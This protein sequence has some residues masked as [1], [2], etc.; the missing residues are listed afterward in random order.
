[1]YEALENGDCTDSFTRDTV[2]DRLEPVYTSMAYIVTFMI[3]SFILF[4]VRCH[5]NDL[6]VPSFMCNVLLFVSC[7]DI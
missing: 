3:V 5:L 4:V 6:V 2:M 1:M 7:H